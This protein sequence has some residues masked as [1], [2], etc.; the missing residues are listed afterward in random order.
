MMRTI[1]TPDVELAISFKFCKFRSDV[2]G[3]LI[4]CVLD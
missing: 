3:T 2:A 4:H 1:I